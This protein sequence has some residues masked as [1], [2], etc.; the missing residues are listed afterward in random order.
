MRRTLGEDHTR[1]ICQLRR[2]LLVLIPGGAKKAL[3]ASRAKA[4]LARVLPR[5]PAGQALGGS[6]PGWSA[7]WSGSTSARKPRTRS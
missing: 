1:M 7:T 6:L 4:L 2:L 3:S 5:D